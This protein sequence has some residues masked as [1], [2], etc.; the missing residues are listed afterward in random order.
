MT[1]KASDEELSVSSRERPDRDDDP[2]VLVLQIRAS[3]LW[4]AFRRERRRIRQRKKEK[5]ERKRK[6]KS[7]E[8][9]NEKE[10]TMKRE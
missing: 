9:K 3:N 5:K 6:Q 4:S 10:K 8:R 7:E 1:V 2:V